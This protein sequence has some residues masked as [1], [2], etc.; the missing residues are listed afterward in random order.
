MSRWKNCEQVIRV[1]DLEDLNP[2]DLDFPEGTQLFINDSLCP[3]YRG[4]WNECKKLWVNK[5]NK[6]MVDGCIKNMVRV[7]INDYF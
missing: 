2:I 6:K 1:K 5:K 7:A 4:L 3:Y